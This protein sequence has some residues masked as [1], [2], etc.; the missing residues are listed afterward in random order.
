MSEPQPIVLVADDERFFREAICDALREAGFACR[1]VA[2]AEEALAARRGSSRRRVGARPR[3]ARCE[4]AAPAAPTARAATDAAR[5]RARHARR[6]GGRA[7]GASARRE[8]LPREA[9]PRRGAGARRAPRAGDLRAGGAPGG[10]ARA[11]AR[12]R[13]A[14]GGALE[15]G[16]GSERADR[17]ARRGSARRSRARSPSCSPRRRRRCCWSTTRAPSCA[18]RR[19]PAPACPPTGWTASPSAPGSRAWCSPRVSRWSRA[20]S[21]PTRASAPASGA[22]ATTRARWR[23]SPCPG[24]TAGSACSAPPIAREARRSART[25]SR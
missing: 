24:A 13:G 7:G 15:A 4:G 19:P 25:S 14:L 6:P 23:R 10:A 5:D 1:S 12:R 2:S 17:I 11:P 16:G 9:P 18:W 20:T 21:T 8:R 22:R 3:I